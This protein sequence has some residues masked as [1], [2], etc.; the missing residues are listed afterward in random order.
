[1]PCFCGENHLSKFDFPGGIGLSGYQSKRKGYR[2]EAEFAKLTK[3]DRVPLSGST[4]QYKH[5]VILPNGWSAEVKRKK[6]GLT[7]LYNWLEKDDV[8]PPDIV[9]FR[10]DHKPWVVAMTLDK[11]LWLLRQNE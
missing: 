5:D 11:F 10:A 4:A 8:D 1:M 6:S 2:G 9:A 3:G 7:T